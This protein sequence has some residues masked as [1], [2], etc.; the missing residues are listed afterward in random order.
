MGSDDVKSL[1]KVY[2]GRNMEE[3]QRFLYLIE[4]SS[5]VDD[6]KKFERKM[7]INC[8]IL[9]SSS[10]R[11]VVKNVFCHK[12]VDVV[13]LQETK[14]SYMTTNKRF[15]GRVLLNLRIRSGLLYWPVEH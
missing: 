15:V 6:T 11:K 4:D 10:K 1:D 12:T 5:K 2:L 7:I 9:S 3:I 13:I 14:V 8:N